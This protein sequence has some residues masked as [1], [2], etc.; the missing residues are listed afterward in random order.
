[1]LWTEDRVTHRGRYY[2]FQDVRIEPKPVQK[3]APPIWIASSPNPALIGE[4][5]YRKALHRVARTADGWMTALL[6]PHE[7]R[8]RWEIIEEFAVTEGRDPRRLGA[9]QH[10]MVN[11]NEDESAA[12]AEAKKFLDLYYSANFTAADLEKW[13]IFGSASRCA[14]VLQE[15]IEAGCRTPIIRLT[16]W[17][18]LGQFH[19]C[20]EKVLPRLR[21]R[22]A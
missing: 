12:R 14:D 15:F 20:I 9:S 6:R 22:P 19:T 11:L 2:Q 3:P 17:H 5:K 8:A 10:I 13:G 4:E 7:F 21:P 16:T 18:P 1:R